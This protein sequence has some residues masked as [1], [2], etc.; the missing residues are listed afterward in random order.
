MSYSFNFLFIHR[1]L[2]FSM[3]VA[4]S[5]N[6]QAA[7]PSSELIQDS[8]YLVTD[9]MPEYPGGEQ[10]LLEFLKQKISYPAKARRNKE[11]GKVIV[12]FV[13]SKIG[14]VEQAIVLKAV[15]PSLDKEALR[16]VGSLP[17]WIPGEKDGEKVAVSY[18]LPISFKYK[19]SGPNDWEPTN[20][21]L[22]VLDGIK[23]PPHF[24]IN[25][26]NPNKLISLRILKP[27]PKEEKAKL[28]TLYGRQSSDGVIAITSNKDEIY[29]ALADT[30]QSL[31]S[32]VQNCEEPAEFPQ[33]PG[34]NVSLFRFIADSIQYPFAPL[35]LKKQGKVIVQFKVDKTGRISNSEVLQ[36]VDYFLDKEAL[37]V[38]GLMPNWIPA[39]KCEQ[40]LDILV[41]LPVLFKLDIPA[42]EKGWERNDKTIILLDGKRIPSTFDL[43]LLSYTNISSYKVLQP[44]TKEITKSLVSKYGKDAVNGVV[45]IETN[46]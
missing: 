36:S 7:N 45:L 44:S 41:T 16:V 6:V 31:N 28:K 42:S 27:F 43:K 37:R 21:T 46:K 17:L 26:L 11:E 24:N 29:Y 34:G 15:S 20:K 39:A 14:K 33:F 10:A 23:M 12:Q 9:K 19:S 18:V 1:Y 32:A 40:K 13:I 5:V 22:I 38:V 4:L 30:M 2:I 8:V 25:I 35:Q 3:L